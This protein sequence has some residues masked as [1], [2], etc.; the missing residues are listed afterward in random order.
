LYYPTWELATIARPLRPVSKK[1]YL[2]TQKKKKLGKKKK[3][4][5]CK[6]R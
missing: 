1:S 4:K 3:E 5:K 2:L 6:K